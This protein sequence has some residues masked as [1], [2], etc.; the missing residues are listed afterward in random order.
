M[1]FIGAALS[2]AALGVGHHVALTPAT[3]VVNESKQ[4]RQRRLLHDGV[5]SHPYPKSKNPP[6][7]RK[8]KRNRLHLSRRVRRKHRRNR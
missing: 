6:P 7:K 2:M 3:V 5:E 1:A 8:L 4:K